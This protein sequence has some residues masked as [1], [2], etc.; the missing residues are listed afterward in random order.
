MI[1]Q[2][3]MLIVLVGLLIGILSVTNKKL[4]I[5]NTNP[6]QLLAI[7]GI[8]SL[9]L[10][11]MVM[12]LYK[13]DSNSKLS[14]NLT[15]QDIY[16]SLLFVILTLLISWILLKLMKNNS[17]S[18]ITLLCA[19]SGLSFAILLGSLILNEKYSMNEFTGFGIFILGILIM[20]YKP[21]N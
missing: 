10:I 6:L 5:S 3:I 2:D 16:Y 11:L 8:L 4:S 17:S 21:F 14:S 1:I 18:N 9:S 15:K 20:A 12:Y 13:K 7:R 19:A